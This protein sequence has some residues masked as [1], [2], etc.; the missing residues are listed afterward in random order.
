MVAP[1]Y[2]GVAAWDAAADPRQVMRNLKQSEMLTVLE[3]DGGAWLKVRLPEGTEGFVRR[4][5]ITEGTSAPAAQPVAQPVTP[6]AQ[7]AAPTAQPVAPAPQPV[8]PAASLGGGT[9]P[10]T[11]RSATTSG[12]L[13]L[14][15]YYRRVFDWSLRSFVTPLF[16][17]W[18]FIGGVALIAI[19]LLGVVVIS[20]AAS[21]ALGVVVLIISPFLFVGLVVTLRMNL[22][23]IIVLFRIEENTR[24]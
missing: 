15:E 12:E 2:N 4:D 21:P 6:A 5:T 13:S 18:M 9:Q 1:K 3:D 23:L 17:R 19:F 7:P 22:E 8:A 24:K 20:L 14:R 10:M 11:H 16:I